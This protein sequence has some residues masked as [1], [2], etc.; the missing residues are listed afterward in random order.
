MTRVRHRSCP[1]SPRHSLPRN[2]QCSPRHSQ[3]LS[4][5]P[6]TYLN[7]L[8]NTNQSTLLTPADLETPAATLLAEVGYPLLEIY[9]E[10]IA[11]LPS[12]STAPTPTPIPAP[13][14]DPAP[15]GGM[16]PAPA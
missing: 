3:T 7:R 9:P 2:P 11:P 14:P 12:D 10:A 1:L 6:S 8:L 13:A 16:R 4:L 15:M 5:R